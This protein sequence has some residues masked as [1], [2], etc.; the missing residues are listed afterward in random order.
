MYY[1]SYEI[2]EHQFER[3]EHRK[4]KVVIVFGDSCLFQVA[5]DTHSAS[6]FLFKDFNYDYLYY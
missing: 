5:R 4:I 1:R 2:I 6:Y 3:S